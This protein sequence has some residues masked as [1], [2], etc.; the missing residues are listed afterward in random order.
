[1]K[2]VSCAGAGYIQQMALGVVDLFQ[3]R[4]ICSGINALLGRNDFIIT[5]HDRYNPKLHALGQ[6]HG[7]DVDEAVVCQHVFA[8]DSIFQA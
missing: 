4:V 6:V 3:L 1:M 5:G 8:E 7:S 2:L